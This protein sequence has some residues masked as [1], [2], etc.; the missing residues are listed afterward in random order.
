MAVAKEEFDLSTP[1]DAESDKHFE[2]VNGVR[3]EKITGGA[4][5]GGVGARLMIA[6]GVHVIQR[7]ELTDEAILPGFGCPLREIFRPPARA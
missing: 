3:E 7:D 5:H 2:L 4:R 6:L 1:S